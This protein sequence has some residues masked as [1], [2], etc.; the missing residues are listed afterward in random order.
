MPEFLLNRL[1]FLVAV[2]GGRLQALLNSGVIMPSAFVLAMLA[3]RGSSS[4]SSRPVDVTEERGVEGTSKLIAHAKDVVEPD[5]GNEDEAL[6]SKGKEKKNYKKDGGS[7]FSRHK[8]SSKRP[9]GLPLCPKSDVVPGGVGCHIGK[10]TETA[11]DSPGSSA[12]I[13]AT[14]KRHLGLVRMPCPPFF[15]MFP[16]LSFFS[17]LW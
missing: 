16:L 1:S 8:R 12:E 3:K 2:V 6:V 4:M 17:F 11:L 15:F 9:R 13:L 5:V 10:I 7:S 14:C